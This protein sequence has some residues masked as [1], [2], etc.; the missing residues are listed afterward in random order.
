ME[1]PW[2]E[3]W[4][5]LERLIT[6]LVLNYCQ[7]QLE[8]GEYY[9][10]LEHTTDLLRKNNKNVKA[11]FKR[12]KAHSAV[13]NEKE[14]RADFLSVVQLD[15]SLTAAVR[16]ELKMLGERMR[17]KHVEDRKRYRGLF[18]QPSKA[19]AERRTTEEMEEVS[20]ENEE[21]P[22][23]I[24]QRAEIE[25]NNKKN[26]LRSERGAGEREA[27][28]KN[29]EMGQSNE[30]EEKKELMAKERKEIHQED[31]FCQK[32]GEKIK[33]QTGNKREEGQGKVGNSGGDDVTD[34]ETFGNKPLG[35]DRWDPREETENAEVE[36]DQKREMGLTP[37][38][39]E[40]ER[41]LSHR[42]SGKETEQATESSVNN[43]GE[44]VA[45]GGSEGK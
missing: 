20:K 21:Q 7:C 35:V 27:D 22:D 8:L 1:K 25:E 2:D 37:P 9:E 32:G 28:A 45:K 12:A 26:L 6:P 40:Q 23:F 16:K 39:E 17:Q 3:D 41:W 24:R 34:C 31:C 18:P 42:D 4:L 44:G 33:I 38:K 43:I 14:A 30:G 19:E 10:V 11:Y 5:K 36:W 29:G 13:W 15:P